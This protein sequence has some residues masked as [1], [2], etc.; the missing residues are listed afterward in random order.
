MN[1]RSNVYILRD[2]VPVVGWQ[3]TRKTTV[4][5]IHQLRRMLLTTG[6]GNG[7][8]KH[9]KGILKKGNIRILIQMWVSKQPRKLQAIQEWGTPMNAK[10]VRSF[11]AYINFYRTFAPH[12]STV[13]VP[14]FKLTT[15]NATFKWK[16]E[17][18]IAFRKIK[19]ILIK[20]VFLLFPKPDQPFYLC[21][22]SSLLGTGAVLQQKDEDGNLRPIEFFS[23]KW[24]A[25]E[26]NYSTPTI[27]RSN[28]RAE[29]L[30][31]NSYW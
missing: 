24:N 22:D 5:F 10:D 25:A 17:Q 2:G 4:V 9:R 26:Y 1:P 13:A 27:I 18:E 20:E 16:E 19:Q 31:S 12:H 30:L 8:C 14:L 23:K 11:M 6:N 3:T 28:T 15:K 7:C 21:F 29:A